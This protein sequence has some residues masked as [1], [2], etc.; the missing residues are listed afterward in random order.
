MGVSSLAYVTFEVA[1]LPVWKDLYTRIYGMQL[2]DRAD[3][4]VDVRMDDVHHRISLIPTGTDRLRSVGW[5]VATAEALDELVATLRGRGLEVTAGDA[6]LCRERGVQMLYRFHDP[7]LSLENELVVGLLT[8]RFAFAPTRGIA[9][10]NTRGMGLG[11]VVFHTHDVDGAVAFYRDVMGFG[12]SDY[13][14]W[15]GIEAVFLHCNPR[16][17]TLAIMNLCMGAESGRFNHIMF[18]ALEQDD[19]GYAY[20]IVLE[21]GIPLLMEM[22]KHSND[23]MNSFYIKTPGGYGIE[24]GWGGRVVGPDWEVRSYDQ[25][26]LYGHKFLG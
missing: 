7:L 21:S 22:G 14:G 15:D 17:H 11:H 26:M 24:Y 25:P 16:H 20:D 23:L 13:M 8:P 18:E 6:A 3:G 9:G 5:E 19:V 12:V 1:D 4:G 10:Y 2:I